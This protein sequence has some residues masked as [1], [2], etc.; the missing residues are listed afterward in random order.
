MS[1]HAIVCRLRQVREEM[2][3]SIVKLLAEHNNVVVVKYTYFARMRHSR[4]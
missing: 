4:P 3:E 2:F 1:V